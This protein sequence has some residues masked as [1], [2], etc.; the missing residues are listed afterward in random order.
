M[1]S[2]CENKKAFVIY[3][4]KGHRVKFKFITNLNY[5]RKKKQTKK[6]KRDIRESWPKGRWYGVGTPDDLEKE[7]QKNMFRYSTVVVWYTISVCHGYTEV[8]P[9][10]FTAH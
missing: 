10:H 9:N 7:N 3:M 1:E 8:I 4:W 6:K 5:T 2:E